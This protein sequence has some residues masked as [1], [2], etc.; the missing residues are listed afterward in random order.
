MAF[1]LAGAEH[2]SDAAGC[3]LEDPGA[4]LDSIDLLTVHDPLLRGPEGSP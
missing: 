2:R 3:R 4:L 1:E